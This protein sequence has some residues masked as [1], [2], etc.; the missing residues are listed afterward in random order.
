MALTPEDIQ[1]IKGLLDNQM[2]EID[3]RFSRVD[4]KVDSLRQEMNER[5]DRVDE[6]LNTMAEEVKEILSIVATEDEVK[7]LKKEVDRIKQH[8]HL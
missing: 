8:L 6:S 7:T 5:F 3:K 2:Q 1:T 4:Q